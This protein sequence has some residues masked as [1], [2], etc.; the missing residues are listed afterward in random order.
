MSF[1][2]AFISQTGDCGKSA[3]AFSLALETLR[4]G[5]NAK[6]ID[7]DK[8]HTTTSEWASDRERYDITPLVSVQR[9]SSALEAI[10][11]EED[12]FLTIYDCPSRAN[13]ATAKIADHVDL[14]VIPTPTSIKSMTLHIDLI[15]RL[16][17]HVEAHKIAVLFSR[18][19]TDSQH[20]IGLNFME[21]P[22]ID[23]K[24]G[25]D[26]KQAGVSIFENY[27]KDMTG[28]EIALNNA[29]GL[30]D[31]SHLNLNQSAKH[32]MNE[33]MLKLV[34]NHNQ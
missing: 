2:I 23:V 20:V 13:E 17:T 19:K 11:A 24:N 9:V 3:L 31:T 34:I 7:L 10:D 26:L 21:N 12:N 27:I 6:I 5:K 33:I 32:A 22:D 28:Y 18:V 15:R 30:T 8:E 4:K 14:V 25:L 1:K 16:L 29:Y